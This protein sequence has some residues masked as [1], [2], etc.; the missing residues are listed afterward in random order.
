MSKSLR[1]QRRVEPFARQPRL[2]D[3]GQRRLPERARELLLRR[4]ELAAERVD[5]LVLRARDVGLLGQE[6]ALKVA[7]RH[8]ELLARALRAAGHFVAQIAGL[9]FAAGVRRW[10]AQRDPQRDDDE[11][12]EQPRRQPFENHARLSQRPGRRDFR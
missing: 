1:R 7:E 8:A 3:L 6:R 4:R 9:P 10:P 2:L 5:L 12:P 11:Q